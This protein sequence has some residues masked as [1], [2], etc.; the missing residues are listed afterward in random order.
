MRQGISAEKMNRVQ[1][2]V[3]RFLAE[4]P[5]AFFAVEAI[6]VGANLCAP[7]RRL[8]LGVLMREK[9]IRPCMWGKY[10]ITPAGVAEVERRS[11]S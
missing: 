9:L 6:D 1:Y 2:D 11:R 7:A 4:A 5:G 3:L 8:A 10:Q